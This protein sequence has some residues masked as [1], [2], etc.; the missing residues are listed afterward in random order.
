MKNINIEEVKRY[1]KRS[2]KKKVK[3][4][5]SLIVLFMM[6]NSIGMAAYITV[7]DGKIGS[8]GKNNIS[9]GSIALNPKTEKDSAV[10][11][12]VVKDYAIAIGLGAEA[13]NSDSVSIGHSTKAN[14]VNSVAIGKEAEVTGAENDAIAIGY[15]AK[16]MQSDKTGANGEAGS[17]AIGKN[18]RT[19]LIKSTAIGIDSEVVSLNTFDKASANGGGQG[20]A[21]GSGSKAVDQATS[22][23]NETY[24]IGRSSI[25][26]G[27]DDNDRFQEKITKEDFNHYFKKL[28]KVIDE[29]GT[30]YGYDKDAR[31]V[32]PNKLRYSP[33]LAAGEGGIAFGT[34][35]LSYGIGATSIGAFSYALGDY[36]TA[37]GAKTRAEGNGAIAIGNE[38]K[39]FSDNS[40]AV[41]NKNEVSENGGMAY[42]YNA[43]SSG[44]NT[45][46][47][48]SNVYGNVNIKTDVS[49]GVHK[50]YNDSNNDDFTV[51]TIDTDFDDKKLK[52]TLG[53]LEKLYKDDQS[54]TTPALVDKK[55][56]FN[57]KEESTGK[58]VKPSNGNNAIVVGTDSV[59]KGENSITFG[60]AAFGM[61]D[62]TV[63]IGSYTYVNGKNSLGLG[64]ASRVFSDNSLSIGVGS[65]I[66]H[67]ANSSLVFGN[68]S[69]VKAKNSLAIGNYSKAEL[70][71]SISI[72]N[73]SNTDYNP[74]WLE[75]PGYAPKGA[76][77]TLTSKGIGVVSIGTIGKERRLTNLA[78]GYRDTDAVNVSQLRS[79]EEKLST[80][81]PD[82]E[83]T[84][85]MNY[86][87]VDKKNTSGEGY[88]AKEIAMKEVYY[89]EYIKLKAKALE[90][91]VRK[92]RNDEHFKDEY[93]KKITDRIKKLE[94][95][96]IK[97]IN[98]AKTNAYGQY[99]DGYIKNKTKT[100]DTIL[101]E[102]S[103]SKD[104]ALAKKQDE[105]LNA[106]EI[107]EVK[108]S[109]YNND[110]A[111][112]AD[113]IALGYGANAKGSQAV[114]IGKNAEGKGN[115]SVVIGT[116]NSGNG[117]ENDTTS[118]IGEIS[119]GE[120]SVSVGNGVK[121]G[122]YSVGIGG[123]VVS[124][125]TAVAIGDRARAIGKF[126]IA[127]GEKAKVEKENGIAFGN[128]ATSTE[129]NAIAIGNSSKATKENAIALGQGA[130][131]E[132]ND[133]V[134]IGNGSEAKSSTD[135]AYLTDD[136]NNGGRTFAVGGTS[137]KRRIT[138]VADGSADSDAVTVAQLKKLSEKG[139]TFKDDNDTKT[140]VGLAEEIK[141][142]GKEENNHR[143]I[144]VTTN[145][146]N[147]E[148]TLSKTLKGITSIENG[149][150]S[151]K[152]TLN[153]DNITINSKKVTGLVNG[154]NDSDAVAYGQ[155]KNPFKVV[156]DNSATG[157][158]QALGKK[159]E[160]TGRKVTNNVISSDA[161]SVNGNNNPKNG[162]YTTE[163]VETFVSSS[164]E[165]T[166]VLVG[167]REDPTFKKITLKDGD[168][169]QVELTPTTDSLSL[170]SK[171]ISGLSNG[172]NDTDA[173]AYGQVKN[174]FKVVA[175]NNANGVDHNLGKKIEITGRKSINDST[176]EA[177]SVN[178]N[179]NPK[180][181]R[182]TTENVETFVRTTGEGTQVL[183]GLRE[184]PTFKKVTAGGENKTE[185]TDSG[186][187]ITK[188]VTEKNNK[189]D[190]VVKFGIDD[191]G[192]ATLTDTQNTT[193][194]PIV[195]EATVGNQKIS[196]AAN[197]ENKKE[198]T[199]TT[200]FNFSD[201][202]NTEAKVED[203]GV[204]KFNLKDKL[205]GITSIEKGDKKAK[206]TLNDDNITVNT[207][208]TGLTDG[209]ISA[210]STDAV[211]GKQLNT[212]KTTADA[213]KSTADTVSSKIT[214]LEGKKLGFTGNS[215]NKVE[216]KLGED[217]AIKG[218]DS[219]ITTEA[220]NNEI[221]ITVKDKGIT[222]AKIADKNITEGKLADELL[223]KINAGNAVATNTITLSGD[224]GA[225]N[226][227]TKTS[228]V[229]LNK[230]GGIEFSITGKDGFKTTASGTKVEIG[231]TENLKN[232]IAK[233]DNLA[234]NAGNTY[235]AKSEL[236]D[237]A[238]KTLDNIDDTGINKIKDTA[239]ESITVKSGTKIS[240]TESEDKTTHKTTYT[241]A[242]DKD[243]VSTLNNIGKISDGKDGKNG[244]AGAGSHGLTGQDGLNGKD[245]TTKVNALRNGEAGTVVFTNKDG[246]RLI[247]GND[248]KYYKPEQLDDK[249][250]VKA[251]AKDKGVENPEL[252][253]VN[254]NGE[255]TKATTLN[256]LASAL[257][258][259]DA[260]KAITVE[261]AK[262]VV[263][264]L[265]TK[266]DGLDKA[267][268]LADLQAIAQAGLDFSGNAGTSHQALGTTLNIKG[269]EGVTYNEDYTSDNVATKVTN[270]NI[271]IGF[272]KSPTFTKVT[273]NEVETGK[274]KIK[275]ELT[276]DKGD[277][278][279]TTIVAGD[280]NGSL[281]VNGKKVATSD[282]AP[283]LY[284]DDQGNIVEKGLDNK[285]YKTADLKDKK[286]DKASGKYY[287]KDQFDSTGK[288]NAGATEATLTPVD[289]DKVRHTLASLTDGS[290]KDAKVLDK[291]ADGKIDTNSKEAINGSQIKTVLDKLGVKIKNG[292]I[293]APT[294]TTLKGAD[295]KDGETKTTLVDGLN[296][297][298]SRVN[299]GIKYKADLGTGGTQQL[300]SVLNVNKATNTLTNTEGT[301]NYVGDNLITK[302]TK[303]D[304]DGSGK[305]EIGFKES[306]T[307]KDLTATNGNF[308]NLKVKEKIVTKEIEFKD[309]VG[310]SLTLV[311]GQDGNLYINGVSVPTAASAPVLY[312][313]KKGERVELAQD[314]NVYKPE[315]IKNL[316]YVKSKGTQAAGFYA[317]DQFEKDTEGHIK[318]D[319]HGN[320]ILKEGAKATDVSS[321]VY[322]D[323][324]VHRLSPIKK[325]K[326][327]TSKL[328]N[329]ADG[330]VTET[331]TDAINGK[332]FYTLSTN[333]IKLTA[334]GV[335]EKSGVKKDDATDAKLLNT[336]G[337]ISF[338]IKGADGIETTAKGTD[339]TVKLKAAYKNKLE[340]LADNANDKYAY[341]DATNLTGLTDDEKA[342]WREAIGLGNA[343]SGTGILSIDA[344][345]TKGT[346]EESTGTSKVKL[347]GK[348][349][350][351][352]VGKDGITVESD[353]DKKLTFGL[354]QATK[355]KL[356]NITKVSD[357]KDGKNG[358]DGTTTA[359]SHGLTG[360]DGLNGKN[361]TDKVNALRNGEAGTVVFT[362]EDGERL[363][364][365]NDGKYYKPNQLE[366]NGDV[367][368]DAKGKGVE[369]PEL[370]VVN[371]NGE[372]TKA[373]TLN[374]LA[375]ALSN[376][377]AG[378]AITAEKAKGVVEALLTKTDGLD[379][380]VNLADLQAIAQA[381]L[382]F[383]GNTGELHRA[384][385]T[386][387][388]I[389]GE[390]TS[391][392]DFGGASDNINVKAIED[393]TNNISKLEIQLAKALKNIESIQNGD[394]KIALDNDKG[395]AINGKDGGI[396][397]VKGKDDKDGVSIKGGDGTNAPTIAFNK[398]DDNKG[399][400]TITGLK[401]FDVNDKTTTY[402]QSG[403][404]A[405]QKEVKDVLNKIN[406][407]G[408]EQSKLKNG[409]LG[410]VVYTDKDGK[411]LAKAN[412]G[413]Y[414]KAEYVEDNGALKVGHSYADEVKVEDILATLVKPDGKTTEPITL[415]NVASALGISKDKKDKNNE[416]LNKLVNKEAK[417]VYK[418]AELNKV[419]TL[420]D[421]Q[422]LAS[423]GI[424]FAGSTGTANKYLGDTITINGSNSKD[425]TEDN[426]ATKYET[427]NIAVKVDR[428]KGDIEVGLAKELSK[429]NS[430]TSEE[431][432]TDKTKTKITLSKD[433]AT[434][435]VEKDV[436]SGNTT[437]TEQVGAKTKIGKDGISL[438]KQG[439]TNPSVSIKAGDTTN[440]PSIDFATTSADNKTVGTGSITGLEYRKASDKTNDYGTGKNIGRAAT[441][442][443]VKEVYDKLSTVEGNI[444]TLNDKGLKFAGNSG[445]T[446]KEN[447]LG[448]TVNIKGEGTEA[449]NF[450]SAK[451]N[452]NVV[453]NDSGVEL[454]LAA[455]L[456]NMK[457]FETE[458]DKD[459]NSTKLDQKGLTITDKDDK[460]SGT[461][462]NPRH[463]IEITKDKIVFTKEYKEGTENKSDNG[464]VIDNSKGTIS[465]VKDG[466]TPDSVVTKRYIDNKL[467]SLD[468]NN[469]FEYYEKNKDAVLGKDGK[470]YK[471]GTIVTEDGKVYAKGTQE[472]EGK[473]FKES[474][475]VTK[476]AD[477]KF[478]KEADIKDKKYDE[479]EK[480]WVGNDGKALT[481]QPT[482]AT[483]EQPLTGDALTNQEDKPTKLIRGKDDKFYPEDAKY[484]EANK[485]YKDKNG[486]ELIGKEA[487]D[488][489][490]KA[491][492]NSKPMTLTNI[493][494]GRM[495][496]NSTDAVNGGQV[497]EALKD[498]LNVDA[499][500]LTDKGKT[501]LIEKLSTGADI[502]KPSNVLVTDKQV[503]E[504]LN[505]NYYNK[506]QVDNMISTIDNK[507]TI[508][509]E[510][511][512]LALGGVANAVAMA[513]LVQVNSYSRHRHNLS[514]AY[515]YYGGSHAL[516]VG[517]SGTNEERNFVYK[518]SG[519]VNN[520]GNLAF[521]VGAGV[522][523]GEEHD[524]FP[525]ID[526]KKIKEV[527]KKLDEAN[528]KISE[529]EDDKKQTAKKF[530]E[531]EDKY[532]NDKKESNKKLQEMERKLE[533]LMKK[534]K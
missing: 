266:N 328:T 242:L 105:I 517:F 323:E 149:D 392:A 235:A 122:N 502:S 216:K 72:G 245:L 482:E 202:T 224:N 407:N 293:E 49:K 247:K 171:K 273:A 207:K 418:E 95:K 121:S 94:E 455:N 490:I 531:L 530:K 406:A 83:D 18:A 486:D 101:K 421:L 80:V 200:G 474:D 131:S 58:K 19:W 126:G 220:K 340:N 497:F 505:K 63:S 349:N 495:I 238:N 141:I 387:L 100:V 192:N 299:S 360:K 244:T 219:S 496:A 259:R 379:K 120:S 436:T 180:N 288:L 176:P 24:A 346:T 52:E 254:A 12:Q 16:V 330:D 246:E 302:Y 249:G 515:G 272:K 507:S 4:T 385:G 91:E 435:G 534:F 107:A 469:P 314:G 317:E 154:S 76:I 335:T 87:S 456:K 420:R 208:I 132:Q 89:K 106:D 292:T 243:T 108:K 294:I 161:W 454:K 480:K 395:V 343:V 391:A 368:E 45:I 36:S 312:T 527:T 56:E 444:K 265:L 133:S 428:K 116:P 282:S 271:E 66:T 251:D 377:D 458:K 508:A 88:K 51:S 123:N 413:K 433:G 286:F 382:D 71:N 333:T 426:F 43:I 135:K 50:Q 453:A 315:D 512:E 117:N 70:E 263:A 13:N 401:D 394:T 221:T 85:M 352:L 409:T 445:T 35:A 118:N 239:R 339:V 231:M 1:L 147:L 237:K 77:S 22:L 372:T 275:D 159:I 163:N 473:Y 218:D 114:A 104:K 90:M 31:L 498:K 471:A 509:L 476:Q 397:V 92:T 55:L 465:G 145:N 128:I 448:D 371:A 173:V 526:N 82:E 457:S 468:G 68:S 167:L 96:G 278:K 175:D 62:N 425:L 308:T 184:D 520:K 229:K 351:K 170:N 463:T 499:D 310:N 492:P 472:V 529:Y 422:F 485:K 295:G 400:G 321:K 210:S 46:A 375:S 470:A 410:T 524:T 113:S 518:L 142:S 230:N 303:N 253:V 506:T 54:Y 127:I 57:G 182:Y 362:N 439:E 69:V 267:V 115:Q 38:T 354:D 345:T 177:W 334:D 503:N 344:F 42:G 150:N 39:V 525:S 240:V 388:Q 380:A 416:I 329:L 146:K 324:V 78:S 256:N 166:K 93:E 193:A 225:D 466:N 79:L 178:G 11:H 236:A 477:G 33:T 160:I 514:A 6:S 373:T 434:F 358:T 378:K 28:L 376:R 29:S 283:V 359:G 513:N 363:I 30:G 206:I 59:A 124:G 138:G 61:Q 185:I 532:E 533:M 459:G 403:V 157:L 467:K 73:H 164:S 464:I 355:D 431:D 440:G 227:P 2:L 262:G 405:T 300:G 337:G 194:S 5:T 285:I 209:T 144:S 366:A 255:T 67:N 169:K 270:G 162:R 34:R 478:Y 110:G 393:A 290:V 519:S 9:R 306:P 386:K 172:T 232:K 190:K 198:T 264:T 447:K 521:G 213:A 222:S 331:S 188:K 415:G 504:H 284:T 427:K 488:V 183:V 215:G 396:L 234:E 44:N 139:I 47:I 332:Q 152:L 442:G 481:T 384:L 268:N 53:K 311:S 361:L 305:L 269:K 419:V 27:S 277:G 460:N 10:Q 17:I 381:G 304:T 103:E 313:N 20:L 338:G 112:G 279:P 432:T 446:T 289:A 130:K 212:V 191:K 449:N 370:R 25:A 7:D 201:G 179:N 399:T 443:A 281:L 65:V 241:V 494:D 451:G 21:I 483:P 336:S 429:V 522:M 296:E 223:T 137:L 516:A 23:G 297:V 364:K 15:Q 322:S 430:I 136:T 528:K 341:K 81:N 412:D 287:N 32:A 365:G 357:G 233:L 423:K 307:F 369:N 125:D 111:T 129:K 140:T 298:I 450:E 404:A 181:G 211:N 461:K 228:A 97:A 402:G 348:E 260:D 510:K 41:G 261:K 257:S 500:N 204:V 40:V 189:I 487:K 475:K 489:V 156:A 26:I 168:T 203:N 452:I 274:A 3:I 327:T 389:V 291:V 37:M 158:D 301:I 523:L 309:A 374:N 383:S 214:A 102:I 8:W 438:T 326:D 390:G 134:A 325:D 174:P 356:S 437:T 414:Y 187:N 74:E 98:D 143:N 398:T 318:R 165:G 14:A 195:T 155:V 417:D 408:T 186:I 199:L 153:N 479:K 148:V 491:Q 484:D 60:H 320:K 99:T 86:L 205:T 276:F 252:R 64:I 501:N 258:N 367:K 109:N 350:F 217:I 342:K 84:S 319:E 248:G 493:G 316:T 48:G 119:A 441:E 511:S 424:T 280:G 75:E 462:D 250:D 151:A 347:D 197:S 196:Y 411:R 226:N 353:S